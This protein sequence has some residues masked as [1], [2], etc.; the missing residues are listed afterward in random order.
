MKIVHLITSLKIG[1][2]ES[3]LVYLLEKMINDGNEHIVIYFYDGP[4]VEKIK[5]LGFKVFKVSGR[6]K[7]YDPWF[8]FRLK[9]LI[10][11]LKP[12]L[13]HSSLWSANIFGRV[14]AKKLN[15]SIVCDLHNDPKFNGKI[16]NLLESATIK[17]PKKFIA[18]SGFV[19][20]TFQ[21]YYPSQK[22]KITVIPNG[23]DY[24]NLHGKV[25][26]NRLQKRDLG[27]GQN[28]FVIG[29]IGRL[30]PIKS[31]DV[32][33]K[34]FALLVNPPQAVCVNNIKLCIV[35]DG[36]EKEKLIQ[37]TKDLQI[38][39][40]V[41]FVGQ[42][43]DA[44]CFYEIFD[45]FAMSSQTEGLSISLLEALCFGLP[46]ITTHQNLKH[47]VISDGK[48]GFLIPNKDFNLFA[49]RLRQLYENPE[50][51]N[52]IRENNLNLIKNNFDISNAVVKYQNVY[53]TYGL[54]SLG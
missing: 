26:Q 22:D 38:D 5:K 8:Y 19:G 21:S 40:K 47:E 6:F 31:F 18:V 51:R 9:N 27:F 53:K 17:I 24:K 48:H 49:K 13:I 12:D 37:L 33:I 3:F 7:L 16:R 44:Y 30:E 14:I 20:K 10:K 42:R 39:D 1:G 4:N 54:K 2:A 46:V 36:T 50:L 25:K 52:N 11:K 34:V 28:D 45:C 29:S 41:F 35:G 15:I 23:I 32:L 43:S